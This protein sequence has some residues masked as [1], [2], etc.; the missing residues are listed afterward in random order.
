MF[1]DLYANQLDE[2]NDFHYT[3]DA[4]WDAAEADEKGAANPEA[5][6][7]CTGRDVWHANPYYKGPAVPHPEDEEAWA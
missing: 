1:D 7:V 6:W 2:H 3:S 4:E 5:A